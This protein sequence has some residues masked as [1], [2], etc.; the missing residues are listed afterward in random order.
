MYRETIYIPAIR[1]SILIGDN[2]LFAAD[3]VANYLWPHFW[4]L[5]KTCDHCKHDVSPIQAPRW[6]LCF[7]YHRSILPWFRG[8]LCQIFPKGFCCE[9]QGS[10]K[11]TNKERTENGTENVV[12]FESKPFDYIQLVETKSEWKLRKRRRTKILNYIQFSY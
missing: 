4:C 5:Q 3:R 8:F 7:H 12:F 1:I 2:K 6:K 10:G 11:Q 9:N